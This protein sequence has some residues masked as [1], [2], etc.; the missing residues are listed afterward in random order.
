[1][2]NGN[3]HWRELENREAQPLGRGEKWSDDGTCVGWIIEPVD[4]SNHFVDRLFRPHLV[5]STRTNQRVFILIFCLF[6]FLSRRD[7][8]AITSPRRTGTLQTL[9]VFTVANSSLSIFRNSQCSS[10]VTNQ[11]D[12]AV[13]DEQSILRNSDLLLEFIFRGWFDRTKALSHQKLE[14]DRSAKGLIDFVHLP[15][16]EAFA[17]MSKEIEK[18]PMVMSHHLS[19]P[20]RSQWKARLASIDRI[21]NDRRRT[22]WAQTWLFVFIADF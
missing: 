12:L 5:F 6:E 3:L 10:M 7:K 14:R 4:R 2:D 16:R 9:T 13:R 19:K 21:R 22:R 15:F 17:W 20:G 18:W 11:G 1:M 8:T